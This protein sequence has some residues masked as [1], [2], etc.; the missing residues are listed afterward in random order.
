VRDKLH[1]RL[2]ESDIDRSALV[3]LGLR[4]LTEAEAVSAA[5]VA[6]EGGEPDA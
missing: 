6:S 2:L 4:Y 5:T 1:S 3:D